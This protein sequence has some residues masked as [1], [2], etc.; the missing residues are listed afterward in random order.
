MEKQ[1]LTGL[2][3]AQIRLLFQLHMVQMMPMSV[4]G[5]NLYISKSHMTTLVD[6]LIKD[7]LVERHP[8]PNDRRVINVSITEEGREKLSSIEEIIRKQLKT[9]I[10]G[11]STPHLQILCSA[12]EE[13]LDILAKIH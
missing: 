8:D 9:I 10:S 5:K 12:S 7:G 4:L 2:H 1:A 3:D 11:L 6:S 13:M